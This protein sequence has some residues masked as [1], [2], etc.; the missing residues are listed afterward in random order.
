MYIRRLHSIFYLGLALLVI[1]TYINIQHWDYRNEAYLTAIA[2]TC[3]FFV[4]VLAEI[5]TSKKPSATAKLTWGISYLLIVLVP[6][7]VTGGIPAAILIYITG[8][9]YLGK[10]RRT[11]LPTRPNEKQFDSIDM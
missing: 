4:L 2:A 10:G 3:I 9:H 5:F 6:I 8:I 11:F 7:F 1:A